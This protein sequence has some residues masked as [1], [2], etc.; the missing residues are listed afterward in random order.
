MQSPFSW[1]KPRQGLGDVQSLK[2]V[3][4]GSTVNA[5]NAADKNQSNRGYGKSNGSI[6]RH[7]SPN[8]PKTWLL[9]S[10]GVSSLICSSCGW[11]W[12]WNATLRRA[13]RRFVTTRYT[14]SCQPGLLREYLAAYTPLVF[15]VLL[16][17]FRVHEFLCRAK[18]E[19]WM[20]SNN[21]PTELVSTSLRFGLDLDRFTFSSLF[22]LDMIASVLHL[23]KHELFFSWWNC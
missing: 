15:S 4:F 10:A 2:K 12:K 19:L 18:N 17:L 1:G 21:G 14:D 13:C 6:K 16:R 22:E 20:P 8:Y 11:F 5:A 7:E 23:S 3:A 9:W